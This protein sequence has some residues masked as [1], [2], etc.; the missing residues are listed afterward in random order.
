M[1]TTTLA[2]TDAAPVRLVP[3][4]DPFVYNGSAPIALP[5]QALTAGGALVVAPLDASSETPTVAAVTGDRLRCLRA[6]NS[7]IRVR[8]GAMRTSFVLQCRPVSHFFPA[9]LVLEVGGPPGQLA[10]I[11]HDSSGQL[12]SDLRF[13]A[14]TVD[15]AVISLR[16]GAVVPRRI[17]TADV[18]L[19]FGGIKT[20]TPVVVVAPVV[21]DTIHLA[22]REYRRWALGPGRYEA[23]VDVPRGASSS[24]VTWRTANA[25]C[26]HEARSG[27][28]L[29]CVV[30]DSGVVA[31]VATV[32]V[33]AFVRIDRRARE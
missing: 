2:C 24:A 13:A 22:A 29:H 9:P 7:E 14:S 31:A 28:V 17:G 20:T 30:A 10:P 6:G 25:N 26:A 12:V 15:T 33:T 27:T 3:M 5:V 8:S 4:A 1:I 21:R 16:P 11:A 32:P 23:R 18:L 19:D